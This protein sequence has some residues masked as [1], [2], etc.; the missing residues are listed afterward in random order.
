MKNSSKKNF[1]GKNNKDYKK[2]SDF[3]RDSKNINRS[4]KIER[5][6]NISSKNKNFENKNKNEKN[7][8]FSSLKRSKSIFKSNTKFSYKNH[9]FLIP[10]WYNQ[11]YSTV[12]EC[13]RLSNLIY[14]IS[15]YFFFT[16]HCR[17]DI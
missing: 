17:T 9:S 14:P 11:F 10:K 6:L 3:G 8:S 2:N 12:T 1:P 7:N 15:H 13:F 16:S 4:E 5:F